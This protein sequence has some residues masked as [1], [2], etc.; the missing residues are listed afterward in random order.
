[1]TLMQLAKK[2][3]RG[4]IVRCDCDHNA[5][6]RV[7]MLGI[8]VECPSCGRTAL[9]ADLTTEYW[10]RPLAQRRPPMTGAVPAE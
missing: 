3:D 1:M 2:S 10:S 7:R 4:W 5:E 6:F 9:T 8:A